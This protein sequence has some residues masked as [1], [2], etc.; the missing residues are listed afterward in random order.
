MTVG[1]EETGK[2]EVH[3][4]AAKS[5]EVPLR[6]SDRGNYLVAPCI[7]E[8]DTRVV[9]GLRDRVVATDRRDCNIGYGI[10]HRD[11]ETNAVCHVVQA[12]RG[13]SPA[14]VEDVEGAA[15]LA[16]AIVLG[17]QHDIDQADGSFLVGAA[18]GTVRGA[19][20]IVRDQSR[21]EH[22]RESY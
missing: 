9:A 22:N 3:G 2:R 21:G 14:D 4:L 20:A 7:L 11:V 12:G 15:G 8:T 16:V 17:H 1:A 6:G 18:G 5:G 10:K 19:S 13:I